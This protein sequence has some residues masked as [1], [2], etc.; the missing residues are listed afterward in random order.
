M[1][2]DVQSWAEWVGTGDLFPTLAAE[3]LFNKF[4]LGHA[5]QQLQ[6]DVNSVKYLNIN[7]YHGLYSYHC[8][9]FGVSSAPSKFQSVMDQILQGL[10]QVTFFMD[11]ILIIAIL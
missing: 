8:L 7:S 1:E 4:V 9:N 6:L 10:D 3:S 2:A 11:D 5:Y